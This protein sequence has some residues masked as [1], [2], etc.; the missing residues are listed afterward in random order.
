MKN[1]PNF[2]GESRFVYWLN[3]SKLALVLGIAG[4]TLIAALILTGIFVAKVY[5]VKWIWQ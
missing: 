1:N 5:L 3:N 2:R 4:G